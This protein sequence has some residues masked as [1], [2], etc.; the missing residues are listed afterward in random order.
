[1]VYIELT[2]E[3]RNEEVVNEAVA[4]LLEN[5][6][7]AKREGDLIMVSHDDGSQATE[8]L[9]E[10]GFLMHAVTYS[11]DDETDDAVFDAVQS[12][13][14]FPVV[15]SHKMIAYMV[16]VIAN[17]MKSL[18]LSVCEDV[19]DRNETVCEATEFSL[20]HVNA[21]TETAAKV[22]MLPR[23]DDDL[24]CEAGDQID[25]AVFNAI[26]ALS[27]KK[28]E[29]DMRYIGNVTMAIES[30]M[31]SFR[32]PSCHPWQDDD[33]NICYSLDD[34]RCAHCQRCKQEE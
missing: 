17:A 24:L 4:H 20:K 15:R 31:E 2:K 21:D 29:W 11:Q 25:N 26:Q 1:M 18:G 30:A 16:S 23:P 28:L 9:A 6:I 32:V 5:G 19:L 13:C 27:D 8:V 33:E 3:F 14:P 34:E 7:N 12:L 22:I 10:R